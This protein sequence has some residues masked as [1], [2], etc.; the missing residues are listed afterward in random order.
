M[1]RQSDFP[2]DELLRQL[3][4]KH[5]G[6]IQFFQFRFSIHQEEHCTRWHIILPQQICILSINTNAMHPLSSTHYLYT[7]TFLNRCRNYYTCLLLIIQD[8]QS[9]IVNLFCSKENKGNSALSLWLTWK[10]LAGIY[11]PRRV[12]GMMFDSSDCMVF[13]HF[14]YWAHFLA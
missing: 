14:S 11:P 5:K 7:C 10:H 1:L 6:S 2:L 3:V 9:W 12:F 8:L 13:S 4:T